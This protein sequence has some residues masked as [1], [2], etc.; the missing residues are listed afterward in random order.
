METQVL[1]IFLAL[2]VLVNPFACLPLF[3]DITKNATP[4]QTRKTALT[5]AVT[6]FITVVIFTLLGETLLK[7]LGISIGS[8]RVGGGILI[9]MI[10]IG[11]M[12]GG[13]NIAKPHVNN[14]Q[15][16]NGAAFQGPASAVVPLTI[17]MVIGPG[18][19]STI[20]IYAA[21]GQSL[22]TNVAIIVAGLIISVITYLSF[23]TAKR[24][25]QFMGETGL[26]VLNRV[27]GMMIAAVAVEIIVAGLRSLFP[28]LA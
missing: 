14:S 27:M 11:M 10:A 24:L 2:V 15:E 4:N 22:R 9:F 21:T 8:F 19:I 3:I 5:S 25:S 6:L 1:K 7:V 17:P 20:I 23:V 28:Q 18:G 16:L 26:N 12:N 13:S